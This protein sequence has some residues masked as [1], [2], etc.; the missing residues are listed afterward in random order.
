[1]HSSDKGF[2]KLTLFFFTFIK[3]FLQHIEVVQLLINKGADV[4][5][6]DIG[7]FTPLHIA[8]YVSINHCSHHIINMSII[9][10][11]GEDI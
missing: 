4:N 1:M 5:A 10:S 3:H 8:A 7:K 11:A 6:Q 9:S 2:A